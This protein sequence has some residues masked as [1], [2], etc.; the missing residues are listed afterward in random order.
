MALLKLSLLGLFLLLTIVVVSSVTADGPVCS[1]STKL[2]LRCNNEK[3]SVV[4]D[5]FH[6]YKVLSEYPVSVKYLL[7]FIVLV[8]YFVFIDRQDLMDY[9]S[10]IPIGRGPKNLLVFSILFYFNFC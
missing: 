4:A 5:F 3:S 9:W 8:F 1:P 6:R 7:L 2:S 10:V